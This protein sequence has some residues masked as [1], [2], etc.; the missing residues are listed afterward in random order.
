MSELDK[1]ALRPFKARVTYTDG[2]GYPYSS[3][4]EID[5]SQ[6]LGTKSTERIVPGN[7]AGARSS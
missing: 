2:D 1:N 4:L 3:T 6:L 5:V 7:M